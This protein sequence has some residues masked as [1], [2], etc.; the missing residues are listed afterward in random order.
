MCDYIVFQCWRP[1]QFHSKDLHS[2]IVAAF[3]TVSA[4][5]LAQPALLNNKYSLHTLLEVVEL[6][7]SGTK[8][9]VSNHS[10]DKGDLEKYR[11]LSRVCGSAQ[12]ITK[13]ESINFS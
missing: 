4:W 13:T 11:G 1:P 7:I 9:H 2:S 12:G 5:V 10:I 6:G 8:S 3:T